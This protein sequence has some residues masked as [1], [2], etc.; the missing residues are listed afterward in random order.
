MPAIFACLE[1]RGLCL[2]GNEVVDIG[3]WE[4]EAS[5]A[6]SIRLSPLTVKCAIDPELTLEQFWQRAKCLAVWDSNEAGADP[7][8]AR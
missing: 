4:G 7:D 3:S 1:Q 5:H 6:I 2:Q 8:S